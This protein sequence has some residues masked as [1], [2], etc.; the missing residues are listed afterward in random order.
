PLLVPYPPLF[1]S[2]A[3]AVLLLDA[4]QRQLDRLLAGVAPA[5]AAALSL[6]VRP[7]VDRHVVSFVALPGARAGM[8]DEGDHMAIDGRTDGKG[9]GRGDSR[10]DTR[11]KAIELALA[12]IEKQYGK[13]SRSEERRVGNE[14][15]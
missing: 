15:R 9:E 8:S 12:S 14:E 13:G 5:V 10:G 1:R 6:A 7:A 4:G 2:R 11:E 3:L